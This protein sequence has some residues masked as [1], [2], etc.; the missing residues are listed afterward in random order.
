MRSP[1]FSRS[2][3]SVTMTISPRAKA[4]MALVTDWGM[5]S[6]LVC[7]VSRRDAREGPAADVAD[8]APVAQIMVREHARHHGFADGNRA[9]AGRRG[10][11][12][13]LVTT[14]ASALRRV[15]EARG[16]RI[17]EV[18]FTAKRATTG[19]PVEMP[20]STPPAL[21]E[22]EHRRAVVAR[23]HLVGAIL[24]GEGRPPRSPSP[25]STPLT[26]LIEHQRAGEL[27]VELAVD[28]RAEPRGHP[29]GDDLDPPRRWKE[30]A[31]RM[32]VE[33]LGPGRPPP[34]RRGRRRGCGRLSSQSQAARSIA[35]G[36]ICTSAPRGW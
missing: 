5:V 28:R 9:D 32:P 14:S 13:A 18:G 33:I 2:S 16:A 15:T 30:P 1:S 23:A 25:I 20:P 21:L 35:C 7:G 27:G 34:S 11:A 12:G 19:W 31:L 24:A 3:S 29:L 17:D 36:P 6:L 4:S 10:R 8:L 26:A 22:R